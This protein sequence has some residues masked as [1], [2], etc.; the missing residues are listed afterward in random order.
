MAM[1]DGP[2]V[3]GKALVRAYL[4]DVFTNGNVAGMDRYLS[5]DTFKASVADLVAT[6]RRAF[7]DFRIVVDDALA[8]GD[9][10]VTVEILSGTHEGVYDSTIGPIEP[11]G[12]TIGW[13]RIAIRTLEDGRFVKGFF[14]EDE[15]GLLRQLGALDLV[16]DRAASHRATGE[17]GAPKAFRVMDAIGGADEGTG[18]DDDPEA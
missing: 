6:W 1:A 18:R 14:E 13:S 9:K 12:R 3:D 4:E 7:P 16:N 15:V 2:S 17:Q 10:V 5:G 11:T 8:D